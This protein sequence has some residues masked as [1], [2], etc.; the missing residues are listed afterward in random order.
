MPNGNH[1]WRVNDT[2]YQA[3][4]LRSFTPRC[5]AYDE[6][7][8]AMWTWPGHQANLRRAGSRSVLVN[9]RDLRELVGFGRRFQ[10]PHTRHATA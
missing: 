6:Y 2:A 3:E 10:G 8:K 4:L 9:L 7:G 5:E 1:L